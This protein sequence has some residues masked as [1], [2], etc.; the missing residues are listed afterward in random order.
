MPN[1]EQR[2]WKSHRQA[3]CATIVV[4]LVHAVILLNVAFTTCVTHDE[5][6]HIP[7]GLWNATEGRFDYENLN[8]PLPRVLSAIPLILAGAKTGDVKDGVDKETRADTFV[9]ANHDR[10]SQLVSYARLA[11]IA[12]SLVT[13]WILAT[14]ALELFGPGAAVVSAVLWCFSPNVLANSCLVT[15][16]TPAACAMLLV[17]RAAWKFADRPTWRGALWLG[18]WLGVAQL[19][20]YTCLLALP[21][22]IAIWWIRRF[23]DVEPVSYTHLTL[24]TKRIV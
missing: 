13:A 17:I 4:L 16:D 21:L 6:W 18:L 15:S 8:P 10:Y 24:P 9:A 12:L 3:L 22:V 1:D 20:K 11:T 7:A 2:K 23:H 19:M 14:W 5:Y